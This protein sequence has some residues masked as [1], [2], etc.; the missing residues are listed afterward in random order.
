MLRPDEVSLARVGGISLPS[1]AG[2]FP[3][4]AQV[5]IT[6]KGVSRVVIG[7]VRP[8]AKHSLIESR[9]INEM[10]HEAND[11]SRENRMKKKFL[12]TRFDLSLEQISFEN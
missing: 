8:D 10:K 2:V 7:L 1:Y 11:G 9:I 5:T 6:Y 12:I 3:T 4:T